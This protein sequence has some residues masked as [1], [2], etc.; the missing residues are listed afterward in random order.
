MRI[1]RFGL[2]PT[3]RALFVGCSEPAPQTGR[4]SN[5]PSP[6]VTSTRASASCQV[7]SSRAGALR[8]PACTPGATNPS[9]TPQVVRETICRSGW[10]QTVRPADSYIE[11]LKPEQVRQYG[12]AGSPH[13]Y[14]EDHLIPLELG[15]APSDSKNL[16]PEQGA[17]PNAKDKV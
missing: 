3:A 15:G 14:E 2:A 10:T 17:S 13:R 1:S 5:T 6:T 11:A 8:D 9:V 12:E 7:R 4:P 16:W